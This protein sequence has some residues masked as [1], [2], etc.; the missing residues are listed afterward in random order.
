MKTTEY[1]IVEVYGQVFVEQRKRFLWIRYWDR[2]TK[3]TYG[4]ESGI[5]PAAFDFQTVNAAKHYIDNQLEIERTC[6]QPP[7]ITPYP[8]SPSQP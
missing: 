5:Y 8:P 1:R 6:S 3:Q 4:G 7:I 2:L